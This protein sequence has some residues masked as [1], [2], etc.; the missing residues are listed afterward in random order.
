MIPQV[1]YFGKFEIRVVKNQHSEIEFCAK[2]I[3]TLLGFKDGKKAIVANCNPKGLPKHDI[4]VG[5]QYINMVFLTR[6]NVDLLI[7]AA[8]RKTKKTFTQFTEFEN[9][10]NEIKMET[11]T[12]QAA[13]STQIFKNNQFGEVRVATNENN[14]PL[15]CLADVCK[16]VGLTNPSNVKSRLDANDVELID[17]HALSSTEGMGNSLANF[18][19]ESGFY[20]VLFQSSSP[21]VKPFRKWVTSE[22]LPSIRKH[23]AYATETTIDNIIENPDFGIK[24]LN[25]LKEEKAEKERLRLIAQE[26]ANELQKSAPKVKYYDE[27]LNSTG[28]LTTN[29]IAATLGISSIKLNKILCDLKIQYKQSGT[30]FL[31]DKFKNKGYEKHEPYPYKDNNG[32]VRTRQQM[33]WKEKGKEFILNIVKKHLTI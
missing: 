4:W 26:Q 13:N 16:S 14:E 17:L 19:N 30:Y 3:V 12:N 27:V 5:S 23:G 18:V 24:L 22:V 6:L 8:K 15:F 28:L 20:D 29:M 21:S 1:H 10:L 11:I 32:E 31:Y 2:D 33:Y 25:K 7:K 9:F